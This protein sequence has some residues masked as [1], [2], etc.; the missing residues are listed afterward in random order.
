MEEKILE[1]LYNEN[2]NKVEWFGD[3]E[4][5]V[6]KPTI[7]ESEIFNDFIYKYFDRINNYFSFLLSVFPEM[8]SP[9]IIKIKNEFFEIEPELYLLDKDEFIKEI[10]KMLN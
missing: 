10:I 4:M 2:S 7:S 1:F 8:E 6:K 5:I 9:F 3:L